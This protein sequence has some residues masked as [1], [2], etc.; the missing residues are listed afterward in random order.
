LPC[1]SMRQKIPN[2]SQHR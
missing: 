1:A 2:S